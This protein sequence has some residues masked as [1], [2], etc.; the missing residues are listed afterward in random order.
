M[1]DL[2]NISDNKISN[3][4]SYL[5][6]YILDASD[7]VKHHNYIIEHNLTGIIQYYSMQG[8]YILLPF[9]SVPR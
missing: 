4:C 1:D 5:K 2:N 9:S 8:S 3:I 6:K 7:I